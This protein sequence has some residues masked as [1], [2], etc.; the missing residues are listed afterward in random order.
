MRGHNIGI[1]QA[2]HR[3][4]T[5][6][7]L[8][9]EHQQAQKSETF[10][11]FGNFGAGEQ[12]TVETERDQTDESRNQTMDE[13]EIHLRMKIRDVASETKRPIGTCEAGVHHSN[14]TAQYK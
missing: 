11:R 10:Q 14:R 9:S 3:L 1:E 4:A 12:D 6:N 5:K 2:N 8:A 13:F 7:D